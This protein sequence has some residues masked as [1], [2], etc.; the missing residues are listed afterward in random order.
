MLFSWHISTTVVAQRLLVLRATEHFLELA[1]RKTTTSLK[2]LH[3][4][5]KLDGHHCMDGLEAAYHSL[6]VP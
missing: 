2:T 6:W 5:D 4:R 3:L 1:R